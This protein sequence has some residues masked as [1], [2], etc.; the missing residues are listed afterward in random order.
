MECVKLWSFWSIVQVV[1]ALSES[2]LY[3]FAICNF[4]ATNIA[5]NARLH[6]LQRVYTHVLELSKTWTELT[7]AEVKLIC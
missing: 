4:S 3:K 6:V 7:W 5:S 1:R 2:A